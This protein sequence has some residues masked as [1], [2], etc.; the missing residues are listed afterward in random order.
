MYRTHAVLILLATA[1]L[2]AA[3]AP[4]AA[5]QTTQA[6]DAPFVSFM[7]TPQSV[8]LQKSDQFPGFGNALVFVDLDDAGVAALKAATG[9]DDFIVLGDEGDQV[10]LRDDAQGGDQV[11]GDLEYTGVVTVDEADLAAR[12]DQDA[13]NA[14]MGST[15]PVFDGRVMTGMEAAQPFDSDGFAAGNKVQLVEPVEL[16]STQMPTTKALKVH[17]GGKIV[18]LP[19]ASHGNV[20]QDKVLMITDPGVVQDPGRTFDPCTGGN[21]NGVWTFK[22][23]VTEMANQPV[24]GI[25]PAVFAEQWLD[26]WLS[27]QTINTF[28][29]PARPNMSSILSSWPRKSDGTLDLDRSPLR[30]L[31][32]VSRLDL[33]TVRGGGSG[34]VTRTGDFLDGGEA[35]FIFGF[36]DG[37]TPL[38]FSVIFEFRVPKCTCT[39]VRGWARQWISLNNY[40]L[41]SSTYN[42]HLERITEQFVRAG[43]APT[44]PNGS[45]I[46]QVRTDETFLS[47]PWELREF[48]L[49]QRFFSFLHEK[50][51]ADTPD[52]SFNGTPAFADWVR[53]G[54]IPGLPNNVPKVPLIFAPHGNFL[55]AHPQEPTAG[56]FWDEPGLAVCTNALEREGRFTASINSCNGCHSGETGTQFVQVDPST[57]LGMPAFLSGFLTGITIN[58][59]ALAARGCGPFM[60]HFDDLDRR[61]LDIRRKARMSCFR[62]HAINVSLVR[63]SLSSSGKLPPSLFG[64]ETPDPPEDQVPITFDPLIENFVTQVH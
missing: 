61:E 1:L 8:F 29:V 54:I 16:L 15:I 52:N 47:S 19:S 26:H 55:G 57:P 43:A 44:R 7:P 33:A 38:P 36:L 25:D 20:F 28:T 50:T 23:L 12:G 49:D 41:G 48:Q 59:P 34:Y 62:A 27:N 6:G 64:T 4:G 35:R 37:C 13:A 40:T 56:F 9:R 5:A 53:G 3:M 42:A 60:R 63:A 11:A 14:A 21:P 46:G 51:S 30:L 31:A 24:S 22:H 39:A 45:A 2:V 17:L 32:I 58:D 10:I 18:S